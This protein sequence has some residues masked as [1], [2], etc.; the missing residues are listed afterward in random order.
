MAL[1][2]V[3]SSSPPTSSTN[4][5]SGPLGNYGFSCKVGTNQIQVTNTG[6]APLQMG[7]TPGAAPG[8]GFYPD[9]ASG[10]PLNQPIPPGQTVT[11][12]VPPGWSGNFYRKTDGPEGKPSKENPANMLELTNAPGG[13]NWD[14][15][16]IDGANAAISSTNAQGQKVGISQSDW[17]QM[18]KEATA[19]NE[20]VKNSQGNITAIKAPT[21]GDIG[22]ATQAAIKNNAWQ[23]EDYYNQTG[24]IVDPNVEK[25]YR[26]YFTNNTYIVPNDD[27]AALQKGNSE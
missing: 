19:N 26:K 20:V 8:G 22:D 9:L 2:G 4:S 21:I 13:M 25:L 16:A 10:P 14:I 7:C 18:V 17:T 6:S 15:T 3:Q 11:V 27:N 5:G 12:N 24:F 1:A 23:V